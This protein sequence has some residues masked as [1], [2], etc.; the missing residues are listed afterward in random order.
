MTAASR[1]RPAPV[2]TEGA[3]SGER[4]PSACWS[5]CINTRFQLSSSCPSSLRRTKSSR[6]SSPFPFPVSR[7]PRMSTR[8]SE[9]GPHGPV[10]PI[11]KKLRSEE[12]TSELQSRLHLVCRLLLE[13][14]KT[15]SQ[16]Q[17]ILQHTHVTHLHLTP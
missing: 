12:H 4:D 8:I 13:K 10:S 14:K 3:G 11:C 9:Q 1:S 16:T 6:L 7:F 17:F 2:S 5:Y 15:D